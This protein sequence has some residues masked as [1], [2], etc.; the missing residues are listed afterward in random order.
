MG[1]SLERV[2]VIP[3]YVRYY[4]KGERGEDPEWIKL[5]MNEIKVFSRDFVRADVSI[6]LGLSPALSTSTESGRQ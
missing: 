2:L 5:S 4:G 3:T 6:F 1:D